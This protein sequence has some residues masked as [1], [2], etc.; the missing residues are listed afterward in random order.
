M[1]ESGV[2]GTQ[3]LRGAATECGALIVQL[4][5]LRS[6]EEESHKVLV[7]HLRGRTIAH[8]H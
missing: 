2:I 7:P 1:E 4:W 8:L 3:Q 6:S 5:D